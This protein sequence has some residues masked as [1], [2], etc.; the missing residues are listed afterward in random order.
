MRNARGAVPAGDLP[1]IY[2][3]LSMSD[4]ADSQRAR[5]GAWTERELARERAAAAARMARAA[6]RGP[7]ANVKEAA[8]LARFANRVAT[9]A[10]AARRHDA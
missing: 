1:T 3:R 5:R 10:A 7:E 6:K 9:A 2:Y 4:G 8:A